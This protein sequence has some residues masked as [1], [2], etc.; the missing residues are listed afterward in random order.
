[1]AWTDTSQDRKLQASRCGEK[2]STG[3]DHGLLTDFHPTRASGM[4]GAVVTCDPY[5]GAFGVV[6]TVPLLIA[7][8]HAAW[9]NSAPRS[10]TA[11]VPLVPSV[12]SVSLVRLLR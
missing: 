3:S 8:A 6:R 9:T 5:T 7:P 4:A 10:P 1:M 2:M 11:R 12:M